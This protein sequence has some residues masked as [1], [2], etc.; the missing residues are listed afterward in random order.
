VATSL[1]AS[2]SV[3]GVEYTISNV[4]YKVLPESNRDVRD[5]VDRA[6][7]RMRLPIEREWRR[8]EED[9]VILARAKRHEV[10]VRLEEVSHRATRLKVE[11]RR[12]AF[13]LLKDRALAAAVISETERELGFDR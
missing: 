2:A 4:A 8:D 12:L 1:L 5:A 6:L 10:E 9:L 7:A 13:H 11:A 3:A